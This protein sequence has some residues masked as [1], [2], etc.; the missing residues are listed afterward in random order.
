MQ[1]QEIE[2]HVGEANFEY[3]PL[4][5]LEI[6]CEAARASQSAPTIDVANAKPRD[7]AASIGVN[8]VIMVNYDKNRV[9]G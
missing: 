9:D 6:V 3:K 4:R 2:I 8:A 7:L 1:V 5:R